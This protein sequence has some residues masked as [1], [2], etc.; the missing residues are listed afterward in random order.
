MTERLR[1]L[2]TGANGQLGRSLQ[3]V[4]TTDELL[5]LPHADADVTDPTVVERIASWRP[6]VVIHAAAMTDV[7]GCERNPDAAYRVNALGTRNVAVACQEANAAMVYISTDYVFDGTK[8]DAY[9]EFDAPNPLSAY[10]A[11][12]LAGEQIVQQLLNRFWIVRTAWLYRPGHRNF[13]STILRLAQQ[14][15]EI[16]VVET[17][18]GSPTY[19]PDLAA[20]IAQLIRR[21]LYGVYH[22]VNRGQCSRYEFARRIVELARLP[23]RVV[24]VKQFPRPAQ[25]PAYAPLRNFAG[26]QI[27]IELRHWEAALRE[28]LAGS[29]ASLDVDTP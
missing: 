24:P 9:W 18:V 3:E 28:C 17:E 5:P 29:E 13:V 22:L 21:P 6:D 27:G 2:I 25:R 4:L 7:D 26:T 14:Q 8:G 19:A 23:A 12:K 16:R 15:D 10:G 1:I 11:S 20:A